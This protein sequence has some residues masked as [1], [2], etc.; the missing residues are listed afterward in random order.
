MKTNCVASSCR[1]CSVSHRAQQDTSAI[2]W[3]DVD[4]V[5]A[6][7]RTT[8]SRVQGTLADLLT[9]RLAEPFAASHDRAESDGACR[10]TRAGLRALREAGR[11]A[12][13]AAQSQII[14]N[15]GMANIAQ[16][17]MAPVFQTIEQPSDV[18]EIRR[19]LDELRRGIATLDVSE[20]ER[21]GVSSSLSK[22]S[23]RSSVPSRGSRCSRFPWQKP[24]ASHH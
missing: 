7:L 22:S 11:P 13:V 10:I 5:A 15:Y 24:S 2:L 14:H 19:L 3:L 6:V 21:R 9:E 12:P 17:G 1:R 23:P 18:A 16:A 8:P 4:G 20:E